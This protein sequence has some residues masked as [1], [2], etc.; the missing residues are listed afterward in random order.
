MIRST[1]SSEAT[2]PKGE[3]N[4]SMK[5]KECIADE[6]TEEVSASK[7]ET[8]EEG[9]HTAAMEDEPVDLP[10]DKTP[11]SIGKEDPI[12]ALFELEISHGTHLTGQIL[13]PRRSPALKELLEKI[14]SPR[15]RKLDV[16]KDPG[17]KV[18][19]SEGQQITDTF[20]GIELVWEFVCTENQQADA[21]NGS[22]SDSSR[23]CRVA[24]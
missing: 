14:S 1:F 12:L 19:T 21:D 23:G 7:E 11:E 20:K 3:K 16:S 9:D 15:I 5:A 2:S 4:E 10:A 18:T 6:Q 8:G 22:G 17:D 13:E 24:H